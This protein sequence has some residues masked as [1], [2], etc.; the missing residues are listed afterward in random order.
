MQLAP[1]AEASR[2]VAATASR[3]AK[4]A[5]LALCLRLAADDPDPAVVPA[6]VAYLSGELPQRRTGLGMAALRGA[7]PP[8]GRALLTVAEVDAAFTRAEA[9]VGPGSTTA[10]HALL[11]DLMARA[12]ADEQRLLR[13]LV[14]GELRQGAA[15]ALVLDAV[16][17]AVGVPVG[18]VRRAMTLSGS[19]AEVAV[20][21]LTDGAAGLAR[22]GLQVGRAL[23]PML[24]QSAPT[25]AAALSAPGRPASRPSWTASACSC[26]AWATRC[27]CSP[28]RSTTSPTDYQTWSRRSA[29]CA[30]AQ[31]FWTARCW[32]S[33]ATDAPA[34]SR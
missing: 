3:I 30:V 21:A 8:S 29:L 32:R 1:V 31:R 26:T 5:R 18:V 9:L 20:S 16:A 27:R 19:P 14:G 10:R 7:P 15:Q 12:D 2:D 24:A 13:G 17:V 25:L 22:F 11:H 28:E 6:V 34:P 33:P 23:A 4:V